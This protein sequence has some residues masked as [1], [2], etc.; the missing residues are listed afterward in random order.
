VAGFHV[1]GPRAVRVDMLERLADLIRALLNWRP[2]PANPGTPPR[3]A[4]GDG[5]FKATQ[6]MMSILGCSAAELGNVLKALGFWS[7]R[8]KI[9]PAIAEQKTPEAAAA[10]ARSNGADVGPVGEAP[11]IAVETAA[12][13]PEAAE[14]VAE[15]VEP[16]AEGVE[17]VP[18]AVAATDPGA[19]AVAIAAEAPAE[20]W[21]EVWRPRRKGRAFE[22][23]P[24][25]H[26]HQGQR[27]SRAR[28]AHVT[29]AAPQP[30]EQKPKP[31]P[32][33]AKERPR[34]P[35]RRRGGSGERQDR[36]RVAM[37][38]SPPS[39]KAGFDPDSPF[40]ALSSL[41]AALEKRSQE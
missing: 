35:E 38:A 36:P 15:A 23:G 37:H 18:I 9:V 25:R 39:G 22:A 21:E 5:G 14:P 8:R 24:E 33:Q 4:T 10:P 20:Q 7:E 31:A 27:P 11:R 13:V 2:D 12:P 28:R 29:P 1:C 26:K 16:I 19:P 17:P 34:R 6:E 30:Q 3:G 41:K 32:Q 40:A